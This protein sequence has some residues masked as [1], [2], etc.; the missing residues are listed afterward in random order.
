MVAFAD[1]APSFI[2]RLLLQA[3]AREGGYVYCIRLPL[4]I[5]GPAFISSCPAVNH[6]IRQDQN[7]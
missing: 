6:R 3:A 2:V 5:L 7:P 4:A 1:D